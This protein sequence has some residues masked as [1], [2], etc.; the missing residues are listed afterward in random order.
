MLADAASVGS[1]RRRNYGLRVATVVAQTAVVPSIFVYGSGGYGRV[2]VCLVL[3]V[4][5]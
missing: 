3:G 1:A 2:I 4:S 5:A